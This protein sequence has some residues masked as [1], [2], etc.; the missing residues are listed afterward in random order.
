MADQ[1]QIDVE[2]LTAEAFAAFGQVLEIPTE[3]GRRAFD[4]TLTS[5][6]PDARARLSLRRVEPTSGLP[7]RATV[8]ERHEHSS[9]TFIAMSGGDWLVAVAPHGDDGLPEPRRMR[10][11]LARAGQCV[12]YAPNVWHHPLVVFAKPTIFAMFIWRDGTPGD[13]EFVDIA[14]ITFAPAAIATTG[15][16]GA[17]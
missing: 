14:P 15:Q 3:P 8:M 11:Y 17:A 9:Q 12:T 13:E 4:D 2:P 10:A 1:R 5:L 7:Y 6:R 16:R